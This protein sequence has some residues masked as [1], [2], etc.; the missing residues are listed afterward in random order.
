[1]SE[2]YSID[3]GIPDCAVAYY[4]GL[5]LVWVAL[6]PSDAWS[7]DPVPVGTD[8]V[9][10]LPQVDGR[11][12]PATG[13]IKLATAGALLSGRLSNCAAKFA[14]PSEWK[15]STKKPIHHAR[16]WNALSDAERGVLGG[17]GT[18]RAID[19]AK[20]RGAADGWRKKSSA[21]YYRAAEM[22]RVDGLR[23]DHN[24]LDAVALGLWHL[25]RIDK[26]GY[27]K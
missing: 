27:P 15:G 26:A 19:A 25:G 13:L 3:P 4:C 10:E 11:G 1:M 7:S 24:I 6:M 2:L 21:A 23:I 9:C 20:K 22:I 12:V 16:M 5:R 18:Q 17:A 8:T 14:T